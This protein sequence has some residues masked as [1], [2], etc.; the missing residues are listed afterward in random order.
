MQGLHTS[1]CQ[2]DLVR[3]GAFYDSS[4]EAKQLLDTLGRSPGKAYLHTELRQPRAIP[5]RDPRLPSRTLLLSQLS[6]MSAVD[7]NCAAVTSKLRLGMRSVDDSAQNSRPVNVFAPRE[8]FCNCPP[9]PP[10]KNKIKPQVLSLNLCQ[11]SLQDV[12]MDSTKRKDVLTVP[13]SYLGHTNPH[14]RSEPSPVLAKVSEACWP[15]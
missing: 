6:P 2:I 15:K 10:T 11:N 4:C 3:M 5:R 13:V 9:P 14:T 12:P 7:G 1:M 8:L